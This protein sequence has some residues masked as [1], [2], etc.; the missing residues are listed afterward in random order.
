MSN[1][2]LEN[3][4][5][6]NIVAEMAESIKDNL[7][8]NFD[9]VSDTADLNDPETRAAFAQSI[10]NFAESLVQKSE[11]KVSADGDNGVTVDIYLSPNAPTWEMNP[12]ISA[13][14]LSNDFQRDGRAAL[15]DY[16][17]MPQEAMPKPELNLYLVEGVKSFVVKAATIEQVEKVYTSYTIRLIGDTCQI[18]DLSDIVVDI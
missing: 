14:E 13:S 11:V 4:A 15:R 7:K 10:S 2:S 8:Y 5:L 6:N 18:E 9:P 12:N 1:E 16:G 17:A 3:T